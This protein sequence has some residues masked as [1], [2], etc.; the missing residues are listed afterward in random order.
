MNFI[1]IKLF[2]VLSKLMWST[3]G[4]SLIIYL[5]IYTGIGLYLNNLRWSVLSTRVGG[6]I[7][8]HIK[9]PKDDIIN[10]YSYKSKTGF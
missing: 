4:V 1:L 10:T 5:T 6:K 9:M 3:T 7:V 2:P 8:Y